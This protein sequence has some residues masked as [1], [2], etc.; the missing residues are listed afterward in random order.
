LLFSSLNDG[1]Y[2]TGDPIG[3]I[4]VA[5]TSQYGGDL[6]KNFGSGGTASLVKIDP[7][8][9]P[10]VVINSIGP[11]PNAFSA[12][13]IAP[14]E[15]I[16]ITGKNLGPGNTATAQLDATGRLPFLVAGTSV[17]FD[18]YL[19]PL[20]TVQDGKVVCFTPFEITGSTVVT[21]KVNGQTSN[22][23]RVRV[24]PTAPY[25]LTIAHQDGSINS[26][27]HPAPQDSVLT[28]YVTGLGLTSPLSQDGSVSARP[29]PVP[30]AAVPAYIGGNPVEPQF[31]AAAYGLVAGITQ[32]NVEVPVATYS[33][34]PVSVFV[35]GAAGQIYVGQ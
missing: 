25:I 22:T 19:A 27:T 33:L 4:Y 11:A 29:L 5:G 28:F 31:V 15:L 1:Q 14:G 7:T 34:N 30:V 18:G 32:V 35:G 24:S 8:S 13:A 21:V 20:I 23:V 3:A 12:V 17:L 9:S 2:L 16:N 6:R 26:A 10:P